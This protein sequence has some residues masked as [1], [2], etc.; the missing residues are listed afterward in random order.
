MA[1]RKTHVKSDKRIKREKEKREEAASR[2]KQQKSKKKS[3]GS[4]KKTVIDTRFTV[5]CAVCLTIDAD[6]LPNFAFP[7]NL[8]TMHH[9]TMHH[10]TVQ[11]PEPAFQG[12]YSRSRKPFGRSSRPVFKM[13]CTE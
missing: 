6:Q 5:S 4:K 8:N 2:A 13:D 9:P 1:V 12:G 10:P 3:L 11:K 7:L